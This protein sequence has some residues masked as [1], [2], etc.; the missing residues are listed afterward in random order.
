MFKTAECFRPE[1]LV[2]VAKDAALA[3]GRAS[4]HQQIVLLTGSQG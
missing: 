2:S 4:A 1:Q 3:Q